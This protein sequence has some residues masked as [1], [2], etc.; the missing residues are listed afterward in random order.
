MWYHQKNIKGGQN[1]H[2]TKIWVNFNCPDGIDL[3]NGTKWKT[4]KNLKT[5]FYLVGIS[6]CFFC[7]ALF[8]KHTAFQE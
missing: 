7:K 4:C 3:W 6:W 5:R 2:G 8:H 1:Y